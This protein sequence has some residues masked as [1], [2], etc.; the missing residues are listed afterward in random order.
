[1]D[2]ICPLC[3]SILEKNLYCDH[4]GGVMYDKGR[5]QEFLDDY[6][7]NMPI[8]NKEGICT[9]IY[10]CYSCGKIK[11]VNFKEVNF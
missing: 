2:K 1:M 4:C 11:K 9:H 10:Q 5:I 3:N 8:E 6:S 7:L